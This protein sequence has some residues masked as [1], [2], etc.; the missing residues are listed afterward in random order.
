MEGSKFDRACSINDIAK[1]IRADIKAAMKKPGT[2]AWA[3]PKGLKVSVRTQKFSGGCSIDANITAFE[4][5]LHN[6]AAV[7]FS[8]ALPHAP[9]AFPWFT[10]EVARVLA[11]LK[12]LM[13]AYN[14][15]K[16]DTQSDYFHVRFYDHQGI[17]SDYSR[18]RRLELLS[19]PAVTTF[20]PDVRITAVSGDLDT[21]KRA[22]AT[23]NEGYD[24]GPTERRELKALLFPPAAKEAA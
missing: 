21:A 2:D 8:E 9:Q 23:M 5:P 7:L 24:D 18:R 4:G 17:D 15:D 22:I 11:V 3:L 12:G 13:D 14:F 1:A 10:K 20:L 6:L 19:S 16:S